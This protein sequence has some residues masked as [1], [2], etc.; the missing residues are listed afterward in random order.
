MEAVVSAATVECPH[1]AHSIQVHKLPP[2]NTTKVFQVLVLVPVLGSPCM[3]IIAEGEDG[4]VF[5]LIIGVLS[6]TSTTIVSTVCV[7]AASCVWPLYTAK[8]WENGPAS[9][10]LVHAR[11]RADIVNVSLEAS[12][13]A[14]L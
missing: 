5:I 2:Y 13:C 11:S 12:S 14:L 7:R 3:R 6:S 9:C 8:M 10:S 4:A 1:V